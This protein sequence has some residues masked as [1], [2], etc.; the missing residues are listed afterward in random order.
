[1]KLH[2]GTWG[3]LDNASSNSERTQS[4]RHLQL[5]GFDLLCIFLSQRDTDFVLP[6]TLR[7]KDGW[8][9]ER[10]GSSW[11][12]RWRGRIHNNPCINIWTH[13]ILG[14]FVLFHGSWEICRSWNTFA[15]HF[16]VLW[17]F[18]HIL[19]GFHLLL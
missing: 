13:L 2:W 9:V 19:I 15:D 1:M 17:Y 12:V 4:C 3:L 10:D 11:H 6:E 18:Y 14:Y 7:R 16:L 8:S 5:T